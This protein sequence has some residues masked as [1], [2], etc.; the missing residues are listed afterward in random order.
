MQ[1]EWIE[2]LVT[3]AARISSGL[4]HNRAEPGRS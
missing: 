1:D 2:D 3:T 4:G